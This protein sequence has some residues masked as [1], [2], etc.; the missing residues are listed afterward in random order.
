MNSQ[1]DY[2]GDYFWGKLIPEDSIVSVVRGCKINK[3]NNL[4]QLK[5]LT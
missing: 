4:N 3:L 2:I 1:D 5:R